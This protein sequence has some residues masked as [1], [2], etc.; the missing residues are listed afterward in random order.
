MR[1]V[2]GVALGEWPQGSVHYFKYW[3]SQAKYLVLVCFFFR[4]HYMNTQGRAA[5]RKLNVCLTPAIQ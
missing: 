3:F 1:V 4:C 5:G 2:A